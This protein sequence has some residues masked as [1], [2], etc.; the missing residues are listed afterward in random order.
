MRIVAAISAGILALS[1]AAAFAQTSIISNTEAEASTSGGGTASASAESKTSVSG[2]SYRTKVRIEENGLI[3]T[4]VREGALPGGT[5][6][7]L[8]V[9]TNTS[10]VRAES[11]LIVE[12]PR[13]ATIS[14]RATSAKSAGARSSISL[15]L[16]NFFS[17]LWIRLGSL[18]GR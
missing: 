16:A 8:R 14:E 17:Q 1:P 7:E 12:R 3:H 11:H 18:F 6:I 15:S 13:A 9:G 10:A 2:G 4:E 5:R